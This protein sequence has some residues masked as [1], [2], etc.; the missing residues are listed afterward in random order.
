MIYSNMAQVRG[1]FNEI[2][3][4]QKNLVAPPTIDFLNESLVFEKTVDK[5]IWEN[6]EDNLVYTIRIVNN[7]PVVDGRQLT[8]ITIEDEL[9]DNV[10]LAQTEG[11]YNITISVGGIAAND[12]YAYNDTEKIITFGSNDP[13]TIAPGQE[14]LITFQVS[15]IPPPTP[16]ET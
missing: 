9:D 8:D 13:F 16:P 14:C 15:K 4:T 2:E 11:A 3:F 5:T 1:R 10:Q 7:E 12:N 6:N